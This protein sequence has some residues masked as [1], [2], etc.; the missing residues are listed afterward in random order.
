[1]TNPLQQLLAAAVLAGVW[2]S[3][4]PSAQAWAGACDDPSDTGPN[5][6]QIP[7]C[8]VQVQPTLNFATFQN[9]EY[10]FTCT[11]DHDVF[12][13]NVLAWLSPGFDYD[14][15]CFSYWNSPSDGHAVL[16][17][18]FYNWCDKPEPLVV[19]LGCMP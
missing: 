11:G 15:N 10:V 14:N 2:C 18:T 7:N 3:L 9:K 19:S 8:E 4:L 5:A 12:L 13:G 17:T 16:R 1:M 6:R